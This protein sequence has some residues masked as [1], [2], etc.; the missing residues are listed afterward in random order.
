M[1][2][3]NLK[4]NRWAKIAA[5]FEI[6]SQKLQFFRIIKILFWV[7]YFTWKLIHKTFFSPTVKFCTFEFKKELIYWRFFVCKTSGV[8][9][10][11]ENKQSAVLLLYHFYWY[12]P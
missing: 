5:A 3:K 6:Y 10:T 2:N 12:L 4:Y 1:S 8:N 9:D 11:S 7:G